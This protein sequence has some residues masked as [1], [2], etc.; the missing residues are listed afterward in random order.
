MKAFPF[1]C[2]LLAAPTVLC[3][4]LQAA[5]S[6]DFVTSVLPT[7]GT[8]MQGAVVRV[9]PADEFIEL[10]KAALEKFAAL[11]PEKQKAISDKAVDMTL[12]EY[13]PDLWP[14]KK[15]YEAYAA[16]WKKAVL[17][18]ATDV[19]LGLSPEGDN[20]YRV[21]SVTRVSETDTMPITMGSL[22]YDANKHVWISN[23]GEMQGKEFKAG[24]NF[25]LGAQTGM[26]WTLTKEDNLSTLH[27][28]VRVTKTTDGKAVFV[29]YNLTEVATASKAPI[30]NH[31]YVI[32][33]P[34]T[35]ASANT[36]KPGRK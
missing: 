10:Q 20:K 28:Q 33:L 12:A 30:A 6:E 1:I 19:A 16:A 23:N 24:E 35:N 34:I 4:T 14:D 36:A 3:S 31:G 26:E 13:D 27:E 11:S 32:L 18:K 9:A 29:Y 7:N 17:V 21:I 2:A 15:D 25:I 22:E 8:L 5:E